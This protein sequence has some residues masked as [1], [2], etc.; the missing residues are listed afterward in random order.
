VSLVAILD[1]D[2]EG[3]LRSA[4]SLIQTAGRAARNVNGRVV[5]YADAVTD[6]MRAALD[7]MD[8][9]RRLQREYN[10]EHGITPASIVK[11]IDDVLSSVYERD[12]VTVPLVKEPQET[13]RTQEELDAHAAT[14]ETEMR[15]AA[16]NLEFE[17]AAALRDRI[18]ALRERELGVAK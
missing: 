12:Y 15:S 4:G 11:E 1:A 6:S 8:R 18:K 16:A 13:F 9:R 5:M 3:F 17:R 10:R 7:E 14:L 2:K